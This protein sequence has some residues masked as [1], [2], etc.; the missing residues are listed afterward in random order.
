MYK[1]IIIVRKDLK[2]GKGK[3]VAHALHAAIGSMKN[4]DKQIIE[5]WENE[6]AKKVVLKL[7]DL[8]EL[9]SIY[10]KVKDSKIPC[11][12]VK[13][14]GL[15]QLKVGTVTALGIGPVEERKIDKITGKLKLL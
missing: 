14:A 8:K 11:F 2:W 5:K 1:Q 3:L 6:G 9:R 10:K 13:D 4:V 15:T 12:L 7:K